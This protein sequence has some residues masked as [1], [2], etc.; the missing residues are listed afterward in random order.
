V[1]S[2]GC[3]VPIPSLATIKFNNLEAIAVNAPTR[4]IPAFN[5]PLSKRFASTRA[6]SV[7]QRASRYSFAERVASVQRKQVILPVL[8]R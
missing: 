8:A 5:L 3:N 6:F 7:E 2:I 1:F 4:F